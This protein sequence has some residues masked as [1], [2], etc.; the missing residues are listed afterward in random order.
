MMMS[1]A[2]YN[3]FKKTSY[4]FLSEIFS[5]LRNTVMI[6]WLAFKINKKNKYVI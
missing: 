4:D 2:Y 1:E 3:E 5:N 6:S